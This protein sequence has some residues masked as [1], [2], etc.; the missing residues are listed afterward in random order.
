MSDHQNNELDARLLEQM[1][2]DFMAESG[3][4]L[5]QLEVLLTRLEQTPADSD[6][7]AEIFRIVHTLKGSSSFVGL[8]HITTLAH[9][10]EDVFSEIREGVLHPG[11]ALIDLMFEAL[12]VLTSLREGA[13]AQN[14]ADVDLAPIL[15]KLDTA[16]IPKKE[17]PAVSS[18]TAPLTDAKTET[19]ESVEFEYQAQPAASQDGTIRVTTAKLDKMMNTIAEL[20]TSRN[21]LLN[22]ADI[23]N[24]E[25]LTD[26]A[27][28]IDRLT[29]QLHKGIM[30][31]RMVPLENLFMRLP[32]VVRNL[33][34]EKN[35][36]VSLILEG[37]ETELDKTLI[38]QIH[39]PLVHMVR[40]CLD[41]GIED[42]D[43]RRAQG[44]PPTGRIR[45][46]ARSRQNNVQIEIEDDGRGIDPQVIKS[47]ALR[48]GL[49]PPAE[50]E[51]LADDQAIHLIFLPG[52]TSAQ[53]VTGI[54]GRGVGMD[55]VKQNIHKLRGII[56]IS[57]ATGQGTTFR[58]QLPL[59]LAVLHALLVQVNE[60][61]YAI[62]L[63]T[64]EETLL[65]A[66][67]EI[68][69]MERQKVIFIRGRAFPLKHF[70]VLLKQ[71]KSARDPLPACQR[72][73][74]Q[75]KIPVVVVGLAEKRVALCVDRLL[76][77]QELVMKSLGSYL[78]RVAGIEGASIL[79]D[80]TV[81]LIVDIEAALG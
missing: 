12:Q 18:D 10:M 69:T 57:T 48:L 70:M 46:S 71:D 6:L 75:G 40:N 22:R 14:N 76:D 67:D 3:E 50:I 59:T 60:R 8:E 29:A 37:G 30:S 55:V 7:I 27:T 53:S 68:Q 45:I 49:L 77:K 17:P 23:L 9:K 25:E 16:L 81:T 58:I 66:P 62:P 61:I 35:K 72:K 5:E 42:V 64:V 41:H 34:R 44:K 32:R 63:N 11:I 24:N 65:V 20:I 31:I 54:S 19:P 13:V 39:D 80:G 73:A 1:R 33:A 51:K 4:L 47:A 74:A 15:Q 36:R 28:V 38:E 21:R 2:I 26:I 78:G 43:T 52:L 79:A 56:D